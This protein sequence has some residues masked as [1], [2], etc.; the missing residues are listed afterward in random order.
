MRGASRG[1]RGH[2]APGGV[3]RRSLWWGWGQ[4]PQI[5]T[6]IGAHP[7]SGACLRIREIIGTSQNVSQRMLLRSRSHMSAAVYPRL[8]IAYRTLSSV[9]PMPFSADSNDAPLLFTNSGQPLTFKVTLA[10]E[11]DGFT[12]MSSFS[13]FVDLVYTSGY[14]FSSQYTVSKSPSAQSAECSRRS[15]ISERTLSRSESSF[16]I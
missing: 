11:P 5:T 16:P 4:S 15:A 9:E 8:T 1:S 10:A 12:A 13:S 3:Q 6:V 14:L 7:D 2:S